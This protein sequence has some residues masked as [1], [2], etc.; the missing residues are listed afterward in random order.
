M[1]TKDYQKKSEI[2]IFLSFFKPH[3]AL[4]LLD[5]TCALFISLID[6]AFPM[7]S[8]WC[9]NTLLPE[10]AYRTFWVVMAIV[11]IAYI[12][13]SLFRYLVVYVGHTFGIRVET[14]IRR[15]LFTH[16][17]AL[18]YDY[19]DNNRT[20][21]ILSRLTTD[22]F[23]ITELAH[24]GPE[25]IF[26]SSLT[27]IG[28]LIIL[29]SIQWRLALVLAITIPLFLVIVWL[30]RKALRDTSRNVKKTTASL[31]A[32]FES[33]ISGMKTSKAFNNEKAE[34]GKFEK[35]N[36]SYRKAKMANYKAMGR[37]NAIMDFFLCSMSAIVISVGGALI[38]KEH[39]DIVDLI[40]FSLYVSTFVSPIR[41]LTNTAELI[42]NGTAGLNRFTE[43][44]RTEPSLKDKENAI[45]L[46][47]VEGNIDIEHVSFSYTEG[48]GVL[49]DVS[50]SIK[51]G[52]MV[53]LVGSSGGGKTTLS[54]LI[55]RFYDVTDGSI[56]I[57]GY[58]VRDVKQ[59]SLH[60]NIG[61]VSQEVFLFADTIANNIRYGN[62]D[63]TMEEIMEAA[64]KAEIYSDILAMPNGFDTNTGER[65]V[66]LS[67][68]QKQR[69]SI[70]RIFLKN[71]PVLIL[72]EATSALDSITETHIQKTFSELSKGRTTIVIAHRLSTVK[73]A[74]RIVVIENGR[75]KEEGSHEELM[76]KNSRYAELVHSQELKD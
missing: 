54:C 20:G 74:D 16:I 48:Q 44:M 35:A 37:F 10:Y 8:R 13:R 68:G 73:N 5:M 7:I 14:D 30:S 67:G 55:P 1:K 34:L 45:E 70:A 46:K 57:D 61:V 50:L 6:L 2:A 58:D 41:S 59:E 36:G 11:F 51:K 40:T 9:M 15:E 28:S 18:S 25:D 17:Q 27:I 75:I 43:I 64:K 53:A 33:G 24:H 56:K 38:M 63:A 62:I 3:I 72:D 21:Q 42:A 12:L 32:D 60:K 52:E 26:I 66:L 65:G 29:F 4:F 71:P 69:I 23:D 47:N 39:L 49:H 31:N 22:L 19:F 76:N